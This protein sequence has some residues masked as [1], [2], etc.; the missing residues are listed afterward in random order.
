MLCIFKQ[1]KIAIIGSRGFTNKQLLDKTLEPLKNKITLV[2]SGGAK[3]ADKLGEQWALDNKIETLIF[4]P[5]WDKH[6]K[7]A[8]FIRNEDIIKNSEVCLAFW[9]G[10]SPGT[11]HSL[12]LCKK[13]D[14]PYKIIFL[15]YEKRIEERLKTMKIKKK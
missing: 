5:D 2:V 13:H 12:T 10:E 8:R 6:G 7:R 11:R 3:G 14:V 1:M 4:L 9:D 15:Q